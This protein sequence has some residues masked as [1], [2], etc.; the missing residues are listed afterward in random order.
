M[1]LIDKDLVSI[2]ETRDLLKKAKEAQKEIAKL[3]QE[4]IDTIC[5]AIAK[6]TFDNRVK[7]AKMAQE[8]TGFG[9]WQDKVLKNAF[10]SRDV[11]NAIKDMKTIGIIKNNPAAKYM[12]VAVPVGVIAGLIP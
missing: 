11:L 5:K 10:A 12:E 4:Q 8:E 9:R 6:A 3:S 7:L 1:G 2:Q